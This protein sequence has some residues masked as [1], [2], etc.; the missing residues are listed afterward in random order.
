MALINAL[1]CHFGWHKWTYNTVTD[2]FV[3]D[4]VVVLTV[5]TSCRCLNQRCE[6]HHLW[7]TVCGFEASVIGFV[8]VQ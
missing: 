1:R 4:G 2:T 5:T 8:P 6:T 3:R 7:W